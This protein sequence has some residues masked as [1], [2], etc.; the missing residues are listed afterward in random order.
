MISIPIKEIFGCLLIITSI[1]DAIKY[2]WAAAKII[3]VK[4]ARG[5]SRKFLNAAI[6]NDIIKLIYGAIILD[7][8]IIA[9]SI[10]ALVTMGYNFYTVYKFYPYRMRGCTN[11]KRPNILLYIRNSLTLNSIRRRL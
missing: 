8:Y 10:F 11:F 4:T 7:V 2:Y 6:I 9:S 5:H 3:E 1:F